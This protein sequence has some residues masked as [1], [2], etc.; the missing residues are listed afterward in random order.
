MLFSTEQLKILPYPEKPMFQCYHDKA[1][2]V[3]IIQGNC[4]D[5]STPWV[6]TKYLN[7]AFAPKAINKFVIVED[8]DWGEKENFVTQQK[9]KMQRSF[10]EYF[11]MDLLH[12]LKTAILKNYYIYG[13]YNERF[14]PSKQVYGKK[15]FMH[16]FL[17]IGC[18]ADKFISVGYV[19]D[20]RFRRFEISNANMLDSIH[21]LSGTEMNLHMISYNAEVKPVPNYQRMLEKLSQYIS[22]ANYCDQPMSMEESR[23]ILSIIRL[24]E[25]FLDEVYKGRTYIDLRY[26]KALY[27]HKWVLAQLVDQFIEDDNEKRKQQEWANN[28]LKRAQLVH[29]LGMKLNFTGNATIITQVSELMDQIIEDETKNIPTLLDLLQTKYSKYLP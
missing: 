26:S 7:C 13:I 2:Q 20:G 16:D 6:C 12:I 4:P 1:F 15:D 22:T 21:G 5:E 11:N 17:L 9:F 18:D 25:F 3:G 14:I 8:D 27:E 10:L 24:K 29:I 28:N 19:A 23:G